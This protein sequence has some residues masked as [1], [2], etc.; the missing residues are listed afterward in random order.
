MDI[1]DYITILDSPLS[2]YEGNTSKIKF[3]KIFVDESFLKIAFHNEEYIK[4]YYYLSNST[5]FLILKNNPPLN[6]GKLV[7]L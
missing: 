2:R 7:L 5:Y 4:N 6:Q 1:F 3:E